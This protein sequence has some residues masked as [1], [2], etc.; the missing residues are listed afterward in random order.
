MA[1]F[2]N[3]NLVVGQTLGA[4]YVTVQLTA[5]NQ[6]VNPGLNQIVFLQSDS[7][8]AASRAFN[9]VDSTV[10]GQQVSFIF[11]SES[12]LSCELLYTPGVGNVIIVSLWS[13]VQ[14]DC[15]TLCW[16]GIVWVEVSRSNISSGPDSF[17]P[18][19][20]SPAAGQVL[21]Y[22][23]TSSDWQ[24]VT[25]SGD[26]TM[27]QTG[28]AQL[29]AGTVVD[30]DINASAAI[31]YSKLAALTSANILV[32]SSGNVA[33]SVSMTGDVTVSNTGVTSIGAGV[34][35]NADV[36]ASASIAYSKLAAL[37]S[38]NILVGSASNVATAVAATG[39][40]TITN[41]GVTAIS[42]G[43]VVNAD[44]NATAGISLSKLESVANGFL[45]IGDVSS[46]AS[47]YPMTGVTL[48]SNTGITSFN[49]SE[50]YPL[51]A[52]TVNLSS[53]DILALHTTPI[54]LL[55]AL[56]GNAYI[57][58]SVGIQFAGASGYAGTTSLVLSI[59]GTTLMEIGSNVLTIA[60]PRSYNC[61]C[62]VYVT[63]SSGG[64]ATDVGLEI[65]SM[66]NL[67]LIL[68]TASAFITGTATAVLTINYG[69]QSI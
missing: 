9:I 54:T 51:Y 48:I 23:S 57:L 37:P 60:P 61:F 2:R 14:Y 50:V 15:L 29:A 4:T 1:N 52:T 17:N 46:V 40:V 38:A 41:A 34:I 19:I 64:V 24:N 59:N 43:V 18:V 28:A 20:S 12:P 66:G 49:R 10:I 27:S 47:Q 6:T 30:A 53:A 69:L 68:S 32:G 42:S 63:P 56:G 33:T 3:G 8:T 55:P 45:V 25:V 39:D 5:N 22:N 13:P 65:T 35:V 36:N 44:I 21:V 11:E 31:A 7:S 62:G 16:D 26:I 58:H 67:P